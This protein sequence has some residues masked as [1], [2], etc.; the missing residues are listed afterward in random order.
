MYRTAAR[1]PNRGR[2]SWLLQFLAHGVLL[3]SRQLGLRNQVFLPRRRLALCV[4][5]DG[6]VLSWDVSQAITD[7]FRNSRRF[8]TRIDGGANPWA[9]HRL[10]VRGVTRSSAAS[11]GRVQ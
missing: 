9:T 10:S 1:M 2:H 5:V 4:R 7:A 3:N 6:P 8:L 11:C